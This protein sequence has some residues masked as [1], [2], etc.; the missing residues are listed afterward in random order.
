MFT[1]R[2]VFK[3]YVREHYDE[4]ALT[5]PNDAKGNMIPP[6]RQL[7]TDWCVSAWERIDSKLVIKAFLSAGIT[8]PDMYG[9]VD[10]GLCANTLERAYLNANFAGLLEGGDEGHGL[11]VAL[12]H[13]DEDRGKSMQRIMFRSIQLII[14]R[15]QQTPL[16]SH[17]P[18]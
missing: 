11:A 16:T 5:A 8:T 14:T 18:R 17:G 13:D 4:Y 9:E 3:L 12:E 1:I 10:T 6:S 2:Q 7:V 15:G